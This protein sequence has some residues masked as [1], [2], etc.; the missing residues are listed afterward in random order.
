MHFQP[1]RDL[2]SMATSDDTT[3]RAS[4]LPPPTT[5]DRAV[6]ASVYAAIGLGVALAIGG[7]GTALFLLLRLL[8][9]VA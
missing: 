9:G 3:L 2:Q 8:G 7:F 6:L 5:T 4:T 1:K